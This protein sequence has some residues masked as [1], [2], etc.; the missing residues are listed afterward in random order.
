MR[1]EKF[2]GRVAGFS[3]NAGTGVR[4]QTGHTPVLLES[5]RMENW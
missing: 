4:G 2:C 5:A 1:N 3:G